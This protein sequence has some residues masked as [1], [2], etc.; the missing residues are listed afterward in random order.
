V[1]DQREQADIR[2]ARLAAMDYRARGYNPLPS[3][4]GAKRPHLKRYAR[5][6]DR[7]VADSILVHWW[8]PAVQLCLGVRWNLVVL[9]LDGP[10]AVEV[11]RSWTL[12]RH[13]PPTWA[14]RHDPLEGMHLWYS[15]PEGITSIPHRAVLWD[16]GQRHSKI[17]LL[18]DKALIVAPPSPNLRT[19]FRYHFLHGQGPD[20]V[21]TP[22]PL[23]RWVLD[24][25]AL[26]PPPPRAPRPPELLPLSRVR[27]D[28]TARSYDWRP[29]RDAIPPEEKMALARQWG[30]VVVADGPN[31]AGWVKCRRAG[32]EDRSPS[33][34]IHHESGAYWEAGRPIITFF[35]LAV[36]LGAFPDWVAACNSLGKAYR[37]QEAR[38]AAG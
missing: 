7:G 13:E 27:H 8:T 15:V 11:W 5:L 12:F 4:P 23:P 25:P 31:Q 17:E 30:L 1:I 16:S 14:V 3:V 6:R 37:V 20:A 19:G 18:G 9:D 10:A 21:P 36:L 22:A 38:H 32:R 35:A 26:A 2:L 29:V 34:S 28:P 33:A 24:H